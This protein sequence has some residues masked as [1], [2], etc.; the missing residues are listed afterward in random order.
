[1]FKME[2]KKRVREKRECGCGSLSLFNL[3]SPSM[4]KILKSSPINIISN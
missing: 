2:I 3:H 1:M 4:K